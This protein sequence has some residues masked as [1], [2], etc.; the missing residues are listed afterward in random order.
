MADEKSKQDVYNM[1]K[2]SSDNEMSNPEK[3]RKVL[4]Y[5]NARGM[6]TSQY[7]ILYK[8]RLEQISSGTD[9][10]SCKCLICRK[11]AAVDGIVCDSC[12]YTYSGGRLTIKRPEVKKTVDARTDS[13]EII[14]AFNSFSDAAGSVASGIK[15]VSSGI[16]KTK[17]IKEDNVVK[18]GVRK[19]ANKVDSLAGGEGDV[20]LK[21]RDL[22]KGVFKHH[23]SDEA[24]KI[25]I[26]GTKTTTP[27][28]KDISTEWPSP[29]L[30]SRVALVL[31]ASFLILE[32][33]WNFISHNTKLLPG[34]IFVGSCIVPISVMV[35][36]FETNA[37]RNISIFRTIQIFFIGGCASLLS[38]LI[39]SNIFPSG[40]T[41]VFGAMMT[42]LIEEV[43]KAVIVAIFI[44]RM[45]DCSYILNGML[46]GSAV[47]AGFAAFESAGYAFNIFNSNVFTTVGFNAMIDNIN[48]RAILAPG[49]HV[50]WAA[51]SGAAIMI[52]L[53]GKRF[54][55]GVLV[56]PRFLGLF[57]IPVILHGLWD[58]LPLQIMLMPILK[59][60]PD[61]T[62]YFVLIFLVWV[63]LL[64]LI[65][66]GLKEA[67]RKANS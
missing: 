3:A 58:M 38:S 20:E 17:I 1:L 10:H 48:I 36:F 34:L 5:I 29:W 33:T 16:S 42:G 52:A 53:G 12:A 11:N 9:P 51:I 2:F 26:C 21:V 46:I 15:Q 56:N 28:I 47:G 14:N 27:S 43:G 18:K 61:N 37:P 45:S 44:S 40:V 32:L 23:S 4:Q 22:F 59:N 67:A 57:V 64:V 19:F 35:F 54:Y 55:W 6:M 30:Y 60:L 7:G 13:Q 24:E 63:V 66:N 31:L 25:F 8:Q 50:A 49:G 62:Y 65:S 41:T 39:L